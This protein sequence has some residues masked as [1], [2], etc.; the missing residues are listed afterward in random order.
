MVSGVETNTIFIKRKPQSSLKARNVVKIVSRS[1][2]SERLLVTIGTRLI[3]LVMIY[4][5]D[6]MTGSF[7]VTVIVVP[8][9]EKDSENSVVILAL[10]N[11]VAVSCVIAK[12]TQHRR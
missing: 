3:A 4:Q 12:R 2:R 1:S 6:T 9:V 7:M 11:A 5:A 10:E 8:T